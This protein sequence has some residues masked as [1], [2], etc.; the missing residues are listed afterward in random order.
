MAEETKESIYL[1]RDGEDLIAWLY[2]MYECRKDNNKLTYKRISTMAEMFFDIVLDT[3]T[4]SSYFNDFNKSVTP[5][6]TQERISDTARDLLLNAHVKNVNSKHRQE[7][8]RKLKEV[9][10]Q[11]LLKELIAES[12]SKLEP[13]KYEFK[14]IEGGESE[15]VLLISD[16]H[17]GQVSDNFFNKFNDEI[18]HQR[19]EHLMNKTR[20][21]CKLNNIKKIHV[22]TL[23]DMINGGI[24]VQ[25]R[26]ESQENLIEQTIGVTEALSHLFNNLSQEFNLELYFCRGNHDRV[27]PSKEEAMNGESFSDIIPWFLKERLKGN[28]RIHF[29]EN[30]IDDE[31]IF[32]DV[33]GQKFIGVHGHKDSYNKAIDNLALFTK[34]IPNYIVMGHFHHSREADLKGVEMIVNPSLCGS[35]RFAIDNR[36]FSK[37]GQKLL[38]VNK[39]EGRY[40]TYFISFK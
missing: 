33:C 32:A 2:R 22:L 36:L 38:M 30:V 19:V 39:D 5:V 11:F 13:L 26:I 18:F 37:A 7:L 9:S 20:E 10:N 29:N 35:D 28:E 23:G 6:M 15:A 34:Q 31:I 8:N 4:I 25:T 3:T 16:W 17:K 14:E 27:T 1:A 40:A 24:H 21:Y 12:V